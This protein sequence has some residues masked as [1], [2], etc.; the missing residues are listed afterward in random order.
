MGL[1]CGC[2]SGSL[3][4]SLVAAETP[5]AY[6]RGMR[7]AEPGSGAAEL[8]VLVWSSLN[9]V[10]QG[11]ILSPAPA[12]FSPPPTLV[13]TI[14]SKAGCTIYFPVLKAGFWQ[15]GSGG[16]SEERWLGALLPSRYRAAVQALLLPGVCPSAWPCA[17]A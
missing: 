12:S 15:P 4:K 17:A 6:L 8:Q 16:L 5:W 14:Q 1:V 10:M 3:V 9:A 7:R 13:V 2:L 11:L